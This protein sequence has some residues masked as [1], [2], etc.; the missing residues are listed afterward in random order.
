MNTKKQSKATQEGRRMSGIEKIY[1]GTWQFNDI[2]EPTAIRLIK[3]A[4]DVGINGFDTARVYA[5]GRAEQLLGRYCTDSAKIVTKVPA[6]NKYAESLSKAYPL[7]YTI[8]KIKESVRALGRPPGTLLLHNWNEQWESESC[9]IIA[10]LLEHVKQFGVN[11]FG[12]SLPNGY[13]GELES[14]SHFTYFDDIEMP[15]NADTPNIDKRRIENIVSLRKNVLVRSLFMHGKDKSNVPGR[16]TSALD[17]KACVVI[18]A[19]NPKQIE[20]WKEFL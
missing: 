2:D 8:D 13:S 16:I 20:E 10:L 4:E 15:L 3:T 5:Q 9:G 1:L 11:R 6:T 19:T 14:T 17:T 7:D 18:G 12:V